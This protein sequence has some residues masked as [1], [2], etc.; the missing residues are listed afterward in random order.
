MMGRERKRGNG[1]EPRKV[2]G[3]EPFELFCA[4]HL[5]L[6]P[7]GKYRFMNVHE[8]ARLFRVSPGEI[9]EA[10]V[11]YDMD[12]DVLVNSD[13]DVSLAQTDIQ[14]APPEIS[15]MEEAK[16][17]YAEFREAHV[18]VRDWRQ[19][20]AE[21]ERENQELFGEQQPGSRQGG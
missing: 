21:A 1:T 18:G 5:G 11:A 3:I 4:Y 7:D 6:A 12:P 16:R 8:V 15:K 9:K 17:L 2:H 13:F 20:L 10:L 14:L 19:E